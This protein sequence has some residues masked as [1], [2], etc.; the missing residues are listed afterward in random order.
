MR[1]HSLTHSHSHTHTHTHT[2][3]LNPNYT[4]MYFLF[5][6]L[7]FF[8][9]FF[10][11]SP[12]PPPLNLPFFYF[13][14]L[15]MRCRSHYWCLFACTEPCNSGQACFWFSQ[16]C[17]IGCSKCDG[18]G[19]R[20]PNYDHCPG[21]SIE[22]TLAPEYRS[23][24]TNS[25]PGSKADIF[26]YNPWRAPGKA[27]VFDSCGMAGGTYEEAFNAGAYNTTK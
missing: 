8:F 22:P 23:A 25:T 18:K 1:S 9:F 2:H 15:L 4:C 3:T 24:N 10:F 19:A 27:P 17:T 21:E 5:F 7:F 11:L 20:L 12:L 16:G 6:F 13:R 14:S 26:K